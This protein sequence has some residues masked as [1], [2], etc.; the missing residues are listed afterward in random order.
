MRK[1]ESKIEERTKT[2]Y[3]STSNYLNTRTIDFSKI[4]KNKVE[5]YI[6]LMREHQMNCVKAGNF[7]EAELA[8]QR[9]IQLKKIQDKKLFKEALKRQNFDTKNFKVQKEKEIKGFRK[10]FNDKY[11]EEISKL[12]DML[13]SIK[14]RHEEELNYYFSNFEKNIPFEMKPSNELIDKQR[15][16]EYY[17]KIEDYPNAHLA[18][19]DVEETKKREKEKFEAEKE[20]KIE[21]ELSK[22]Q[23]KH[24]N[25]IQ[26]MQ[27]K[28]ENHKNQLLREQASKIYELELKYRNKERALERTQKAERDSYER[29]IY[30]KNKRR[31]NRSLSMPKEY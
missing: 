16:L 6:E 31:F 4:N 2:D 5:E 7:I 26:A 8:K 11:V 21:R 24:N 28:I 18:Q 17:I 12:E 1:N 22:M 20:K 25:E 9:V 30:N 23:L 3:L 15:Q 10:E 29:M 19:I 27:L 13:N 14:K